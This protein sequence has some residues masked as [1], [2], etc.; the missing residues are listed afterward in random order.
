MTD[1]VLHTKPVLAHTAAFD[2]SVTPSRAPTTADGPASMLVPTIGSLYERF[3]LFRQFL[4]HMVAVNASEAIKGGF[5][6]R[7]VDWDLFRGTVA[8]THS[9]EAALGRAATIADRITRGAPDDTHVIPIDPSAGLTDQTFFAFSVADALPDFGDGS[10]YRTRVKKAARALRTR[11]VVVSG[12]ALLVPALLPENRGRCTGIRIVPP[13]PGHCVRQAGATLQNGRWGR[14][15][16]SGDHT[17]RQI[18]AVAGNLGFLR[19]EEI[20]TGTEVLEQR[21]PRNNSTRLAVS[22]DGKTAAVWKGPNTRN[23]Y[24]WEWQEGG[25]PRELRVPRH[26][27]QELTFSPD[28]KSLVA[29][30][31]H[32]SYVWEWDIATGRLRDEVVLRDDIT[33][34]GL[35]LHP[36]G[37]TM[38]VSDYGNRKDKQL[39]GGVLLLERGTGRIV[40]ELP[41]PVLQPAVSASRSTAAGSRLSPGAASTFGTCEA[42]RKWPRPRPVI[43]SRSPDYDGAEWADR[44]R[45][46]RSHGPALGR[47]NRQGCR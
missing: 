22:P 45:R 40:R 21:F 15:P 13:A 43:R 39:S 37:K 3:E 2:H 36:D 12:A 46:R 7:P 18:P 19:I 24:L 8:D 34:F 44:H 4:D 11:R 25:E 27:L 10:R 20:A 32:E 47:R 38:A 30:S 23:L 9:V 5:E 16:G 28:G 14:R 41:T 26:G 31:S 33:P 1:S 29:C 17:R 42:A 35:A 6:P